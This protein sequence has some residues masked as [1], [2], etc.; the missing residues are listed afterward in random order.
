MIDALP[1]GEFYVRCACHAQYTLEEKTLR[2][3]DSVDVKIVTQYCVITLLSRV[4]KTQN[5]IYDN[6]YFLRE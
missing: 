4:L 6:E 2:E 5:I 3:W 1:G